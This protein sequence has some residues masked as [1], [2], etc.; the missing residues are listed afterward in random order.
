VEFQPAAGGPE[1]QRFVHFQ[2]AQTENRALVQLRM[3]PA[4]TWSL[5]TYLRHG[6]AGLTLLDR[7]ASHPAGRWYVVALTFD[8][9]SMSHFVDR[10]REQSGDIAFKPLAAGR[11]SIGVRQ[12]RIS[13]FKGRI[14]SIRITPRA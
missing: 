13:W 4:G 5:D 9:R 14:R 1:E 6:D 12:N 11:T 7:N 3:T 10:V 8:G 2:E